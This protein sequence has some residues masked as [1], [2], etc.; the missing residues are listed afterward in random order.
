MFAN[1][2]LGT[3]RAKN[4]TSNFTTGV[5]KSGGEQH[6]DMKHGHWMSL[7]HLLTGNP[8]GARSRQNLV[9]GILP[10]AAR[11][12][13]KKITHKLCSIA[14]VVMLLLLLL[15]VAKRFL[16]LPNFLRWSQSLPF[17]IEYT[18]YASS[19]FKTMTRPS[20][21]DQPADRPW[22]PLLSWQLEE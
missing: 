18:L 20:F 17:E 10:R 19:R 5:P 22:S 11:P 4:Q 16:I 21:R 1:L 12:F 14:T 6:Q 8:P 2:H 13:C 9:S 7:A 15:F 3:P